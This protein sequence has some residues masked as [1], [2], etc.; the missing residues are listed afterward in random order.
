VEILV[1]GPFMAN[2]FRPVLPQDKQAPNITTAF[3]EGEPI[4]LPDLREGISSAA[5]EI[6]L[7]AGFR[8]LLV[9][10]LVRGE[11]IVGMLVVRRRTPGVFPQRRF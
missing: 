4:Q 9:T 2:G 11:E 10:P 7:R 1:V 5:N 6:I 3:L 8:A